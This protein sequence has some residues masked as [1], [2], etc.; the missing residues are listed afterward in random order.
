MAKYT[1]PFSKPVKLD[2]N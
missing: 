2:H 1:L